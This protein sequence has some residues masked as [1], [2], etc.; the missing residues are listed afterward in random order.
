M[1]TPVSTSSAWIAAPT[2]QAPRQRGKIDALEA[3]AAYA[4]SVA[5]VDVAGRMVELSV[6]RIEG[7]GFTVLARVH[8]R[9][10]PQVQDLS[11][12]SVD[13]RLCQEAGVRGDESCRYHKHVLVEVLHAIDLRGSVGRAGESIL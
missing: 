7:D 11:T 8:Y 10:E 6:H 5:I 3:D 9:S 13:G 12:H 2:G 1:V 4:R